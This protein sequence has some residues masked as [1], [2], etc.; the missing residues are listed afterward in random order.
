MADLLRLATLAVAEMVGQ[1]LRGGCFVLT[2]GNASTRRLRRQTSD[3]DK[4]LAQAC[5]RQRLAYYRR[6][7]ELVALRDLL[8]VERAGY[9]K[10]RHLGAMRA[11]G[12]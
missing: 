6:G 7:A 8:I 12:P 11:G 9:H 1:K 10:R 3:P 2:R 4:L 5:P